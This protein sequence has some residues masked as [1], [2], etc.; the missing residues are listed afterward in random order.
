[1]GG[2]RVHPPSRG[3]Q[4]EEAAPSGTTSSSHGAQPLGLQ[5]LLEP[6]ALLA[7]VAWRGEVVLG[8]AEG[9]GGAGGVEG[10]GGVGVQGGLGVG[11]A[12]PAGGG[13]VVGGA[14][15]VP[16]WPIQPLDVT[17]ERGGGVHLPHWRRQTNVCNEK[18]TPYSL[19][20]SV[21]CSL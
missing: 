4:V 17:Q 7:V 18:K 20:Q 16:P 9:G 11:A 13:R 6:G 2:G 10:G 1:M 14:Q 21:C 19:K 12:R 15:R 8:R 3:G 5:G